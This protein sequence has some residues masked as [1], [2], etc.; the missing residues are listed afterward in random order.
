MHLLTLAVRAAD[1]PCPARTRGSHHLPPDTDTHT[2]TTPCWACVRSA[3]WVVIT[4][5]AMAWIVASHMLD[6]TDLDLSRLR[7]SAGF[8]AGARDKPAA[9]GGDAADDAKAAA[10]QA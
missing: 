5:C 9:A 8:G 4:M 1:L 10:D 6:A 3:G 7:P 2:P